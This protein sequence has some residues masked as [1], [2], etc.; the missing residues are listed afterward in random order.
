MDDTWFEKW[1]DGYNRVMQV[2]F[3]DLQSAANGLNL[4]DH[5]FWRRIYIRSLF[6]TVEADIFQR[7]QL[8]L[9]GHDISPIFNEGE[10]TVLRELQ[11]NVKMNG[12]ISE[13]T[14]FIPLAANYRLSFQLAGR[15]I[16]TRFQLDVG[17]QAWQDF[18]RCIEIRHKITHP[19]TPGDIE[20]SQQDAEMA[21]RVSSWCSRNGGQ[22]FREAKELG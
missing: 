13:T 16:G 18:C 9:A 11:Y 10:L 22:F 19:K 6:A 8:A 21:T 2:L 12:S 1:L 5:P 7:K 20:V 3:S 17:G 4:V 14:R 15:V